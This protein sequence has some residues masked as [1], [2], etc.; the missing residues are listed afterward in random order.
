MNGRD[1]EHH[2]VEWNREKVVRFWNYFSSQPSHEQRYAS[3]QMGDA[4]LDLLGPHVP[5]KG[6]EVLDFG[7]GPGFLVEKLVRRGAKT[8]AA[9]FSES[10]LDAT[11]AKVAHHPNFTGATLLG[12]LPSPLES[13]RFDVVFFIETIEHLLPDDLHATLKELARV[14]KPNGLLVITTRNEEDLDFEKVPCPDCG[15]VFHR[16]QHLTSWS[17]GSLSALLD[18]FGFERVITRTVL[19]RPFKRF[20]RIYELL[21]T[22]AGT[23]KVNLV[24]VGRKR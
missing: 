13:G 10:S 9:D 5:L 12:E 19:F 7:C 15:G 6:R 18:T 20:S 4:L 24:Y 14:L 16:V 1:F 21:F 11:R 22:L 2:E 23:K 17:A 8:H 3:N